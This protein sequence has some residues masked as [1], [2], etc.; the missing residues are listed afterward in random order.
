MFSSAFVCLFVCLL[1]GLCAKTDHPL[2]TK[3]VWKEVRDNVSRD[4]YDYRPTPPYVSSGLCWTW[5]MLRNQRPWRTDAHYWERLH[6]F[7][8]ITLLELLSI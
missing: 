1:A 7:K 2:L 6:V 4:I 5:R 3:I 8:Y